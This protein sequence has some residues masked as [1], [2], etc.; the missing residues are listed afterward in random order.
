MRDFE[1]RNANCHE[2]ATLWRII[3]M[4]GFWF[5]FAKL[6]PLMREGARR[7]EGSYGTQITLIPQIITVPLSCR[8][9][10]HMRDYQCYRL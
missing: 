6:L 5:R 10:P 8:S 4:R 9:V 2:V 3:A 7:S 1:L